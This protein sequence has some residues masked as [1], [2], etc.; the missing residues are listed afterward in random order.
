MN[1]LFVNREEELRF[2][3]KYYKDEKASLIVIYGRRRIGKTELIKQFIKRR[4]HAYYLCERT[5]LQ[6]NIEKFKEILAEA[7][8]IDWLKSIEV[9]DFEALFKML[10]NELIKKKIVIVFDEFPYLIE[11]DRGIV[12]VFQ[13]IWDEI[14]VNTKAMLILCG[15]SIG[16][17][18][19]EVLGYRSPLYGRRT[20]QWKV[21]E[22]EIKYI[23]N[24]LP[25]YNFEGFL[26]TYAVVGGIPF[27]LLK[28]EKKKGVF[29]NIK[30]QFLWKG[31]F[32]TRKLKIC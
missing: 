6:K 14:L 5:T 18:E 25:N 7:L 9:K 8:E 2:L 32:F 30:E 21:S 1:Q 4:K 17:M 28:F 29:E 23:G 20:A 26:Y 27:Y 16:V 3:E 13:K 31:G 12:S 22:M 15:S 19:T 24:F 10:K 11:I